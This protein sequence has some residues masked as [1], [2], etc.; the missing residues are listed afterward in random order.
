MTF[1]CWLNL[2]FASPHLPSEVA[3]WGDWVK[4]QH[5]EGACIDQKATNCAWIGT[6]KLFLQDD[7]G[8]FFL[9]GSLDAAE[10]IP[11]PGGPEL[12]PVNVQLN[13][14]HAPVLERDG[15]PHI[16]G[17]AGDFE[18]EGTIVWNALP[19]ELPIPSSVG[20]V[21]AHIDNIPMVM[22]LDEKGQLLLQQEDPSN[23]NPPILTVSR[24]WSD[25]PTPTLTTH[26]SVQNASQ[27]QIVDFGSIALES[28][29]LIETTGSMSHWMDE[30]QHL[31]VYAP[32]G[33]HEFQY[34]HA[35]EP[36]I[37]NIPVPE[38][39]DNWPSVEHWAIDSH[40]AQRQI[41]LTGLRP[42]AT[43]QSL[44]PQSWHDHPTYTKE[45]N[46]TVEFDVLLRGN[47][48]PPPNDLTQYRQIW[49]K[50]N[51]NG[52]WIQDEITG[53]MTQ[54]WMLR[55]PVELNIQSVEQ[56]NFAQSIVEKSDS[57]DGQNAVSI[58]IRT[59]N[60]DVTV[61]SDT[62]STKVPHGQWNTDFSNTQFL[63]WV[64][65]SWMVLY[66]DGIIWNTLL[67]ALFNIALALCFAWRFRS[68]SKL[69]IPIVFGVGL[70]GLIAPTS[71]FVWQC[72][73]W[74]CV[75]TKKHHWLFI[76]S[77]LWGIFALHESQTLP[78]HNAQQEHL[79]TSIM[80]DML[81]EDV[82]YRSER[83]MPK[84]DRSFYTQNNTQT[85]QMG[86]GLPTWTGSP[87]QKSWTS[88]PSA[89]QMTL[90]SLKTHHKRWI[91][92]LAGILIVGT[93]WL[94]TNAQTIGRSSLLLVGL[95][96][97]LWTPSEAHAQDSSGVT[98]LTSSNLPS[99][100][101]EQLLLKHLFP[102]TCQTDC[103]N[104]A[105]SK[106]SVDD[107]TQRLKVWMEVHAVEDA[108]LTLPGPIDQWAI[109]SVLWEGSPT[110]ALRKSNEGYLEVRVPKGIWSIDIAGHLNDGMQIHWPV[111]PH[112]MDTETGNWIVQGM[113]ENGQIGDRIGLTQSA[114]TS[115][116]LNHTGLIKWTKDVHLD[117]QWTV[118]NTL[119]RETKDAHVALNI[120]LRLPANVQLLSSHAVTTEDGWRISF[121]KGETEVS[122]TTVHL[123]ED[124]F[125]LEHTTFDNVPTALTWRVQCG[126]ALHCEFEGPP[127]TTHISRLGEWIPTWHPYPGETLRIQSS[128]LISKPGETT[129][130]QSLHLLHRL[131]TD[132][133]ET[134]A[135]FELESSASQPVEFTLP[136]QAT[137]TTVKMNGIPYPYQPNQ[138]LKLL[139]N[140]GTDS[141]TIA[142]KL[143]NDG[144]THQLP[145][146]TINLPISNPTIEVE[147]GNDMV[148]I[149]GSNV[150]N[151]NAPPWWSSLLLL[152][153]L[154]LG[155]ARH[156]NSK[157]SFGVWIIILFGVA[158]T[159]VTAGALL[160]PLLIVHQL[161]P[162]S[163]K[164]I[165]LEISLGLIL[166]VSTLSLLITPALSIWLWGHANLE[167][168]TDLERNLPTIEV[169]GLPAHWIQISWFGWLLWM[170]VDLLPPL[171]TD[172][173]GYMQGIVGASNDTPN[174]G[175]ESSEPTE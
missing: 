65:S 148:L 108:I 67:G 77:V 19:N 14:R 92:I 122:W 137:I 134:T 120:P 53:T 38:P 116:R 85:I 143:S 103:V 39:P 50:L 25:G 145:A 74:L 75:H 47:P 86:I 81:E 13:G 173:M 140:I 93:G 164:T 153:L 54:K 89:E 41:N 139:T 66:W 91:A 20:I 4:S 49:P 170:L 26:I 68:T 10:W 105:L 96:G 121:P 37:L 90:W 18:I 60:V 55:P 149:W 146:P 157:R 64:P 123:I 6:L 128:A 69:N 5:P 98:T 34:I 158:H 94:R 175:S 161:S 29:E 131:E 84:K 99:A 142:W 114:S 115:S 17:A 21:Q 61:I 51:G 27:A 100:E 172:L 79:D 162:R 159:G 3:E 82:L 156:P 97:A 101:V 95:T 87:I 28:G 12:W 24:L 163:N 35:L 56:S 130:V 71:T 119:K 30:R 32:A 168:Y 126:T 154:A 171:F 150:W 80:N 155:L 136:E 169:I 127:P 33:I 147:H 23:I 78:I 141:V 112:R 63:L 133:I 46:D 43:V 58:P 135:T 62:S 36:Q 104:I 57:K 83:V 48:S 165:L 44:T 174:A 129:Q 111:L 110:H 167:W 16:Y 1:L 70:G 15:T 125:T 160:L 73:H 31:F 102:D 124:Q 45:A 88:Q 118:L 113:L 109:D 59:Q 11:L 8:R 166:C 76:L 107:N 132:L 52:F 40:I 22:Q 72:L 117:T 2:A 152:G 42:I 138:A 106:L 144:W 9:Q 151:H 7:E